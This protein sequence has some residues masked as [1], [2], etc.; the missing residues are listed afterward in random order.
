MI[1]FE[2]SVISK[3][4][5]LPVGERKETLHLG[6]EQKILPFDASASQA[7]AD[8]LSTARTQGLAISTADGYI[9]ATAKRHGL[10]VAT[11]DASPFEAAGLT[12]INPWTVQ[13]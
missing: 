6:L 4:L 1:L 12:V 5:K 8:I 7:Y 11:R 9:A 13:H 10:I 3:S 2:T